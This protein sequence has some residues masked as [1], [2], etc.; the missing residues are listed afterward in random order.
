VGAS[1]QSTAASRGVRI[2]GSNAG[3]TIF[4]GSVKSTSYPLHS[5][6]SASLPLPCVTV[7]HHISTDLYDRFCFQQNAPSKR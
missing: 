5:P 4:R 7:S 6:V 3:Y 2:S 1:V